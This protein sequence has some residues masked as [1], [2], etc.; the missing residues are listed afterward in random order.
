MS[1][2]LE[3]FAIAPASGPANLTAPQRR[4][5]TGK[6]R[7]IRAVFEAGVPTV[8]T[9]VV[10]R[11]AWEAL[12]AER[13]QRADRLRAHW[14]ATL[15]RLVGPD[16]RPPLLAVR[17]AADG[18][19]PGLMPA[20]TG[21]PAPASE[22]EA[23][24]LRAPLGRAIATAFDSY[25][26]AAD[27]IV[28]VQAMAPGE[29]VQFMSR[30]A[31]TGAMGP[32]PL[33]NGDIPLAPDAARLCE[34]VDRAAGRHM[35]ITAAI[36]A[37]TLSFLSARPYPASASA[38]LEAATDRVERGTWSEQQAVASVSPDR[39][40]SLLHPSL[41]G[42]HGDPVAT[43][44][45]VSP[46]AA[47][48][49]IVFTAEDA[50]RWKARGR[51]VILVV[52][53]TGPADIDGMRAATGILTA[54]GGMTSH[55]GVI[56]RITG[57]PCVAG[58]RNLSVDPVAMTARI[59][60][61]VLR[62]GDRITIDGSDGS[63]YLGALPLSQ[64]HIGGA[65]GE[66]LGWSDATRSIEVRTNAETLEATSTALSF[67]AEGIGLA[68]SEHMFFS[69]ERL[70]ALR[71]LILSQDEAD[72]RAA[73]NGLVDFQTGDYSAIF[74]LMA[75]RPVTVRLFDPPLHEFL[76][77]TEEEID[78]TAKSLG[79]ELRAL[80]QRL[81][82]ISE[83]NPMLG[84][85]GIRLAV[86]YPEILEMQV[87]ALL[88]GVRAA[89][90]TGAEPVTLEIMVPFVS[91]AHEVLWVRERVMDLLDAANLPRSTRERFAFGTMIELPRAALRAA[92]IARHVD[93]FSF[94]TNDLTQTTYGIS[95][96]DAPAFL[97][98]YQRMGLFEL[99]PFVTLDQK[100]VGE[101]I[102]LAI[103]RG[104]QANPA[105]RIGICGEHAG[106]P[107]SLAFFAR[108]GVDYVSCSP[109]R[110]PIARLAL[111]QAA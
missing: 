104:R 63:V 36:E 92:D 46:G 1:L 86:T 76:P 43:G 47:H 103:A 49:G 82:R 24:D 56:A 70:V 109:Y 62:G 77:R 55:A 18:P 111:A 58:V 102:S 4:L 81:E 107:A 65:L 101:L 44:L 26:G 60:D 35:G 78:E 5:L 9:I 64:P 73:L 22:A 99:D 23:V 57:K 52:N 48:G 84:H 90:K 20:R 89:M 41:R 105:L 66:L 108:L 15:F 12:Q 31:A 85:R 2:A 83:I 95:R 32:A 80:K 79:L 91:T 38:E 72:R 69:R 59:G 19:R 97:A 106:D 33:Q 87:Q 30:D 51:H 37:G 45:G 100:G 110:V 61:T 13:Q 96:D 27:S 71:R 16:G 29:I 10:T 68:R 7:W 8:P 93:F 34:V 6:A 14:V 54:R 28:L 88:A 53:E 74:S 21:L 40:Q 42:G 39:L 17:T 25:P 94:G 50:A 11:A 3:M 75:G 98:A 67:G